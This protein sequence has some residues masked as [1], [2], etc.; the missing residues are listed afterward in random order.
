L[1]LELLS[2]IYTSWDDL[3]EG[4]EY[5]RGTPVTL[6]FTTVIQNYGAF[7]S[8]VFQGV[9][10]DG[11]I[12]EGLGFCNVL[13]HLLEFTVLPGEDFRG[14]PGCHGEV[15]WGG[16]CVVKELGYILIVRLR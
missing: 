10:Q 2:N 1:A 11:K 15:F 5:P 16:G 14:K 12:M 9:S 6:N 7:T 4:I 13:G 3:A 8:C